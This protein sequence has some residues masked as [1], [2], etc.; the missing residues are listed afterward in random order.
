[1]VQPCL[2]SKSGLEVTGDFERD[3]RYVLSLDAVCSVQDNQAVCILLSYV[4]MPS[5]PKQHLL[6]LQATTQDTHAWQAQWA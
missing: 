3:A 1:M 5:E 6:A 2:A 4:A